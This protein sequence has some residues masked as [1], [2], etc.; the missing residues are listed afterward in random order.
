MIKAVIFDFDDTLVESRLVK[1]AHHKFVAKKFYDIDLMDE[2]IRPH[3]GKP[4]HTLVSILYKDRDTKENMYDAL[5]S[6]RED[7]RKKPYKYSSDV[8]SSLL[9]N[10]IH[11]GVLSAT[12]KKF[13]FLDLQD[14]GFPVDKMIAIQGA[15]E[16]DVHKP[17][18][19]VFRPILARLEME[20]IKKEET[21]YVGDSLDDFT[22]ATLAGMGF[23][24]V[25]TGLY[26]RE[27]FEKNGATC[28][29]NNIQEIIKELNSL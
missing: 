10:G 14:A 15:D 23:I 29:V 21:I 11:V 5:I 2:D 4:L 22:A 16:T 12:N 1:W 3:W 8:V 13:L 19:E 17:N 7:F 28:I 25:T 18:P 6:V 27:D 9:T 24:A 20:G 26:S